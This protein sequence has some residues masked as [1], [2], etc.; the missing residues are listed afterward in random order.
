MNTYSEEKRS[1]IKIIIKYVN[2]LTVVTNTYLYIHIRTL[3]T[4][5]QRTIY[6]YVNKYLHTKKLSDCVVHLL[7]LETFSQFFKQCLMFERITKYNLDFFGH[8]H[9]KKPI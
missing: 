1:L 2:E 7:F 6:I 5:K 4:F 9:N 8:K 3:H